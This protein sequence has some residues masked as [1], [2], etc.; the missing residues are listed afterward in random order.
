MFNLR[1]LSR[2]L[3]L[4]N[5][6]QLKFNGLELKPIIS[7]LLKMSGYWLIRTPDMRDV[8]EMGNFLANDLVCFRI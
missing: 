7:L 6:G 5:R 8:N 1:D 3:L 4:T 2:T